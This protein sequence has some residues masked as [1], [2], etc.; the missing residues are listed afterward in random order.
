MD[1]HPDCLLNQQIIMMGCEHWGDSE[2]GTR[3]KRTG[4]NLKL[5]F[6]NRIFRA[7]TGFSGNGGSRSPKRAFLSS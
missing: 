4:A 6:P 5:W 1:T 2:Q 7:E 3:E